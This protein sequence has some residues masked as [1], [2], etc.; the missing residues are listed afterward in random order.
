MDDVIVQVQGLSKS[1]KKQPIVSDISFSLK[2]GGILALCG[3][4][5]AGKS[6]VLRMLAGILQPTAGSVSVNGISREH[7][8]R[9]Y[10][11]QI[12]YMPDD[13]Q[14]QPGFAARETLLF[15][16]SLRKVSKERVEEVLAMVGLEAAGKKR[17]GSF[18]KGM[19]QRLLLA[20]ALLAKPPALL[21]DEPTNGLDPFWTREFVRL[22][23]QIRQDGGTMIFS[24]H[25]LEVAEELADHVVFLHRG[26]VAGEG[27][28]RFFRDRHR[29]L[30]DAF[31]ASLGLE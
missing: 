20:Q 24:T 5:G 11:E 8:R 6:T 13:F 3:G 22:L 30:H 10:A 12:G 29:S 2:K 17:V 4:N 18:S 26:R 9:L 23:K 21:M 31:H 25:Q 16:A 15:W 27:S 7:N 28:V 19:R 14:F 1:I